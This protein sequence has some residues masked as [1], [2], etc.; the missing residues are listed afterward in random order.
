M[1]M[2][3]KIQELAIN[4][5]KAIDTVF[6]DTVEYSNAHSNLESIK[7]NLIASAYETGTIDGK[8]A[9][10]RKAQ[11]QAFLADKKLYTDALQMANYYR[12]Q[13]LLSEADVKIIEH[14]TGLI[15]AYL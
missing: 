5:K 11:E 4:Y 12:S 1:D 6:N 2:L 8:N 14:E 3:A 10:I 7:T 15:K 13:L 9:E